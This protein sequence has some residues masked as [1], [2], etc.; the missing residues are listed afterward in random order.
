M[1][2]KK[3][4]WSILFIIITTTVVAQQG[5]FIPQRAKIFFNGNHSTIFSNVINQGQLGIG[6]NAVLNFTGNK[7]ENNSQSLITD[8]SDNGNGTQG[9]GGIVRFLSIGFYGN[10]P[11][12]LLTGGYNAA[13]NTGPTFY[14]IDISNPSGVSLTDAS[15]KVR[16]GLY[17]TDGHVYTNGQILTIGDNNPGIISGYNEKA[18]VVTS[19]SGGMLLR[20][21][22]SRADGQVVFPI[23]A[24]DGLYTPAAIRLESNNPDNFYARVLNGVVEGPS[25]GRSLNERSVNKTW[26][27]GKLQRPGLDAIEITLLHLT[28]EEGPIFTNN[29]SRAYISQYINGQWDE[30]TLQSISLPSSAFSS[31][32]S[33]AKWGSNSRIFRGT[34]STESYF[35]KFT[36]ELP[37]ATIDFKIFPNPTPDVFYI[38]IGINDNLAAY[39]IVIWDVVG[40]KLREERVNGRPIIEMRGLIPGTYVVGL[41]SNIGKLIEGKKLIVTGY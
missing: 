24:A 23:G 3:I 21:Q 15:T 32:S 13:T 14:N 4:I 17:F 12:Q 31:G 2:Y 19:S 38:S 6:K 39:T 40:Q 16:N 41:V 33:A 25:T 22:I 10:Q 30:G 1:L 27:I 5:F 7:W 37:G 11:L 34:V 29:R 26:Q 9:E 18:F 36:K 8:E 20:E 35:T 28:A